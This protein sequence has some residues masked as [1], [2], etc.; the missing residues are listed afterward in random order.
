MWFFIKDEGIIF[1]KDRRGKNE[2]MK[3]LKMKR[4]KNK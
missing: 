2:K 3:G 4:F 1:I